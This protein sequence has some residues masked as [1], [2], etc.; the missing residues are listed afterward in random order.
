MNFTISPTPIKPNTR[1]FLPADFQITDWAGL[2]LF[3]KNLVSREITNIDEL[4]SWMHNRSELEEIISERGGWNYIKMTCHT[5]NKEYLA[6][7][8][9]FINEIDPNVSKYNNDLNQKFIKIPFISQLVGKEWEILKRNI[10]KDIELFREE[11]IPLFTEIQNKQK[12]YGQIVGAMTIQHDGQEITL[13][14]ASDF[15]E[16]TDRKLRNEVYLKIQD[17]RLKEKDVLNTLYS[18]LIQ[19]RNKVAHNAGFKNFRDYMFVA[20]GRF[21]YSVNDCFAFHQAIETHIA[22]ITNSFSKER[23]DALKLDVLKPYDLSVDKQGKS[24]LRPFSS[25]QDLLNKTIKCFD[26]IDSN[27]GNS[28]RMLESMQRLDLESRKNKAPGGYN[29]PLYESGVPFIFMNATSNFRDMITLLHEGGH[30]LQSI[31][32]HDLELIDF[33]SFP[34]EIAEL[35]S[36]S[37][38]LITIDHWDIFFPD[39]EEC[40]R[41]K[42]KHLE[43]CLETLPWVAIIDKFQHWVYENPSHS[44]QDRESKWLEIYSAFSSKEIDWNEL[45]HIKPF[46]WQKQLH[47]FEVPF[48]YIEY[49]MAQLGALAV[50]KSYKENSQKTIE[51]YMQALSLGYTKSIGEVYAAAGIKFDFSEDYIKSLAEFVKNEI[52]K[53]QKSA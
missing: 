30:A 8:E 52:I 11:N 51:N 5:D 22:P 16:S 42:L 49:G 14:K 38:E 4:K 36:M 10:K 48:Y 9:F 39:A 50:W 46:V 3:Y 32:T 13:P 2:E 40:K 37:M 47:L 44:L 12:E 27:I 28:L 7:Y 41:A 34:S 20:M 17:R 43:Q 24:P 6:D 45:E 1:S 33:K 31:L 23:K 15:L 53:I 35:A 26:A 19:L 18:D 21:D 25:S 29:Y